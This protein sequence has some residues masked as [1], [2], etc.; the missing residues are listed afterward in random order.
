MKRCL[1]IVGTLLCLAAP[2]WAQNGMIFSTNLNAA[3][4]FAWQLNFNG[5]WTLS[6]PRDGIVVDASSPVDPA[7]KGDFVVLPNFTVT[8]VSTQETAAGLIATATLT[9]GGAMTIVDKTSGATV[10]TAT[11]PADGLMTL[12]PN[13]I[14]YGLQGNDLNITSSA[15][16]GT[17]IPSLV[18]AQNSGISIDMSFSGNVP[19]ADLSGLILGRS[20]S[21]QGGLSGQIHAI[22]APGAILLGGIGL[23]L[24]GW[25]RR[26]Q[27][28]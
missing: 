28:L 23:G 4:N 25:M 18:A 20:G 24:V 19:G 6:F 10:M 17:V 8:N 15:N 22:P 26:R 5:V 7:L 14:A 1:W 11:M 27:S 13:F 3:E 9:P 2:L 12:G 16:V 21:A